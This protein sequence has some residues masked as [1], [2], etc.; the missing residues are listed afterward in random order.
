L[1][2]PHRILE[3]DLRFRLLLDDNRVCAVTISSN[4][5]DDEVRSG[6]FE[7]DKLKVRVGI[8][9]V[10]SIS[11]NAMLSTLAVAHIGRAV[12]FIEHRVIPYVVAPLDATLGNLRNLSGAS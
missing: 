11:L 5:G 7:N 8:A 4:V 12:Q 6:T 1:L 10:G 9:Q 2:E 3:D